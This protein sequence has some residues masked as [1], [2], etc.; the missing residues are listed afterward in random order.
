MSSHFYAVL[1]T[2]NLRVK[3]GRAQLLVLLVVLVCIEPAID[4]ID[5]I[6]LLTVVYHQESLLPLGRRY[7]WTAMVYK[8][9]D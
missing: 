6:H 2:S 1:V 8:E 4:F 5:L 9:A 3:L 7:K